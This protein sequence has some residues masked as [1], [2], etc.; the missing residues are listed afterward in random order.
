MVSITVQDQVSFT[1]KYSLIATISHSGT[2]K[3][4][5]YWAFYQGLSLIFLVLLQWQIGF[6]CWRKVSQQYYIIHPFLQKSLDVPQDLPKKHWRFCSLQGGFVIPDIV[7]GCDDPTYN[8]SPVREFSFLTQFSGFITLQ[9]L[10][11]KKHCKGARSSMVLSM[12]SDD[13]AYNHSPP[14][15]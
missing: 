14:N 3:R 8:P 11:S 15:S 2:L 13:L 6:E 1:N 4:S 12:R 9:S 7:F 5:H 10:V